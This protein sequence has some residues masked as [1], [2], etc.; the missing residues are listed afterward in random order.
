[1]NDT[2]STD[3]TVHDVDGARMWLLALGLLVLTLVV[4]LPATEGGFIW[5]DDYY[6][7]RNSTLGVV[8]GLYRIWFE[9]GATQDYYPLTFT[10][11]WL[12]WWFWGTHPFGYHLVNIL[13]HAF[14]GILLWRLLDRLRVP[15]AFFA[16]VLFA[17]HPVHVESV[18][19]VTERK[20]VLS[21]LFCLLSLLSFVHFLRLDEQAEAP[22]RRRW[23]FYA[24]SIGAFFLAML[25]KTAVVPLPLILPVLAWWKRG[26]LEP[27]E[28]LLVAPYFLVVVPLFVIAFLGEANYGGAGVNIVATEGA[29]WNLS[30]LERTL[31]CGRVLWF[32]F[33]K[34]VWPHPLI[35]VYPRWHID[36]QAEWQYL[37]P[38]AAVAVPVILFMLRKRIGRGPLAAAL[39]FGLMLSPAAGYFNFYFQRYSYVADHLQYFASVAVTTLF[40]SL[41]TLAARRLAVPRDWGAT[42]AAALVVILM[43]VG[44]RQQAAYQNLETLWSDTLAKNP[45]AWMA[46]D[47]LG[48]SFQLSN[49]LDAAVA[50]H[51]KATEINPRDFMAYYNLGNALQR[52]GQ[53]KEAVA[54]YLKALELAPKFVPARN[55]LGIALSKM[56]RLS[57]AEAQYQQ[58]LCIEPSNFIAHNGLGVVLARQG[59]YRE[60]AD[61]FQEAVRLQPESV[62]AGDNLRSAQQR[63]QQ[64]SDH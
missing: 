13:L 2:E 37:Y 29:D 63:L 58:I 54:P 42:L 17:V 5:D 8:D 34:L 52:Q 18:A 32:Y 20:N 6:V 33:A 23:R 46:H 45:K 64:P 27:R 56:G 26:R 41:V 48:V 16:A 44:W 7:E 38:L 25:A 61:R 14:N 10:T 28:L 60:A 36:S 15:G 9:F 57:E 62:E 30:L 11:Y 53:L 50:H 22:A 40:A 35:F 21:G 39:V 3:A 49:N 59:R 47:G 12:E 4:Y 51:R 1:L 24:L 19:W 43:L 31:L 55:H